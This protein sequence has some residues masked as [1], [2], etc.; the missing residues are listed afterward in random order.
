MKYTTTIS[1]DG[2]IST[3]NNGTE[4]VSVK[5]DVHLFEEDE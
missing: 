3:Y 5:C 2:K 1:K 4:T